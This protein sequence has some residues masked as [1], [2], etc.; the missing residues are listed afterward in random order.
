VQ[1]IYIV[2]NS[3]QHQH[4]LPTTHVVYSHPFISYSAF[5]AWGFMLNDLWP[6]ALEHYYHLRCS[7]CSILCPVW[8]SCAHYV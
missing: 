1:V 5:Y 3:V 8:S 7:I 2:V 6:S 4:S